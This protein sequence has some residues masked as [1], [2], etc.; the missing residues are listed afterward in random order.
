MPLVS[1]IVA[2][3]VLLPIFG[4]SVLVVAAIG[5]LASVRAQSALR[6]VA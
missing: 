4:G 1:T 5:K 2:L 6:E 3:C